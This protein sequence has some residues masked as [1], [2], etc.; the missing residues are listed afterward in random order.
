MKYK[1][2]NT[3][4]YDNYIQ[5]LLRARGID[6]YEKVIHPTEDCLQSWR[7]LDNIEKGV[8][9]IKETIN[10]D[11]PYA[12]IMDCDMDGVTSTT[13]IYEYLKKLNP[14]KKIECFIHSGKQHGFSDL[15]D[16]LLDEEWSLIIAPDSA[17]NDGKYIKQFNCPVLCADHHIY[18]EENE[19]PPNMILINNQT[20]P[21]YKNKGLSGAGVTWQLCRALD[22]EL[23]HNYAA[24]LIDLAATS[25]ISDMMPMTEAENQYIV[26]EGIKPQNIKNEMLKVLFDK[27]SYSM[28]NKVT[29]IGIAFYIVPLINAM[30]RVGTME[31]K[32]RLLDAF[33]NPLKLVEC[34][35]RGAVGTMERV[36]IESARECVNAKSH[37]DKMKEKACESLEMKIFKN[38]LLENEILF[39][40]LDEEDTFPATIN[41]LVAMYFTSKYHKPTIVARKGVDGYDKGSARAPSNTELTSFKDYLLGTGLFD[42][43]QGHDQAFGI[44]LLEKNLDSLHEKANNDLSK[45]DFGESIYSVDFVRDA[46]DDKDISNIIV[47]MDS[48]NYVF[49]QQLSEPL[50]AIKNIHLNNSNISIIGKNKDTIRFYIGD[51]CYIKFRAKDDI[52]K[53]ESIE[54][55]KITLVGKMAI[56]HWGD[57]DTPQILITD[58]DIEDNRFSF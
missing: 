54:D 50:I 5:N 23:Q 19:I 10:S 48:I 3:G 46:K 35:K 24:D 9:V 20:S 49:G 52:E 1:L 39:I 4:I 37:Q 8:E 18:E 21:K 55:L 40:E 44:S 11:I 41:G 6:D 36:C 29:P 53:I 12:I 38:D 17:T 57:I 22:N 7:F 16:E 33:I 34:H 15:M 32:R 30:I 45:I 42:L 43:A 25:I 56:N 51:V 47:A 13:I 26:Q 2:M 31:E 28:G 14:N 27:Q 58:W